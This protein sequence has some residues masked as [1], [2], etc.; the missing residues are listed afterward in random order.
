MIELDAW[1]KYNELNRG[2]S[3]DTTTNYRHAVLRLGEWM[4]ASGK[5][6]KTVTTEDL[7]KYCGEVLHGMGL[8]GSTR[9][10]S[11]SA[12]RGYFSWL[13][14]RKIRHQNPATGVPYPKLGRSLPVPLTTA[15]AEKLLAAPDLDTFKG[16]R[17]V[18]MLAVMIGCGPRV[19][20]LCSLNEEDLLFSANE[21]GAEELTIR[22]REKGKHERYVPAPEEVRLLVRAY[23]G[24]PELDEIERRL[25]D[26]RRVL[27]VNLANHQVPAHERM[28]ENRRLTK[29][30]IWEIIQ[31]YGEECDIDPRLLHPH[32]M[33]HLYGQELSEAKTDILVMQKLMGHRDPKSTEVYAH[34]AFRRLREAAIAGNPLNRIKNPATGLAAALRKATSPRS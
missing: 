24:H 12:I 6:I 2:N 21:Q 20:G 29:W 28:G 22:L 23:L 15:A 5:S 27:F 3:K 1:L 11:V 32:A 19:S 33:R 9:R 13:V 25:P 16:V 4:N 34:I 8:S 31:A 18:A 14:D 26:G 30:S 17:D 10:I 7:Q